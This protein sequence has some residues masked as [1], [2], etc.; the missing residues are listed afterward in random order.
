LA[1]AGTH[2]WVTNQ[3]GNS[4]TEID[5]SNGSWLQT[6]HAAK[7]GFDQP[8][9][10]V[11]SGSDL[12]IA[13]GSGSVTEVAAK[14]GKLV[15]V[16][17]GDQYGFDNPVAI[18]HSGSTILVLNAGDPSADPAVAGS[19]TEINGATGAFV[20]L[21]SG[22]SY[23]LDDPVALS[24]SGGDAFVADEDSD[25]VTEIGVS[26]GALVRVVSGG[27]LSSPD[28]IAASDGDVWVADSASSA[29][30][31]I[32]AASGHQI[33]TYTD[34]DGDYGFA[35]PSVTIATGGDVFVATPFGT[36]PMV[37]KVQASDGSAQ[38]YTCNTNGP[39][40]FSLLSA[41]AVSGDNLWVASRSGANNPNPDASTGSL[42]ELLTTTGGLETTLPSS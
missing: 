3:A 6:F 11:K 10:I 18:A 17:S 5:T 4:L 12:F 37:T 39:Y 42:T 35:S 21:I 30:T 16:I 14:D 34:A 2:L 22:S 32:S 24:V 26:T 31:E 13:N 1:V 9:A 23:S 27:G 36:S 20:A 7:Y 29:L 8:V 38:W 40:Y 15:R 33:A 25:S 28:G 41:F 19:V